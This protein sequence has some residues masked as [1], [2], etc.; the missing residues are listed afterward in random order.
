MREQLAMDFRA[1]QPRSRATDPDT[2]RETARRIK[3]SRTQI[4][5]DTILGI[6]IM[7]GPQSDEA[8]LHELRNVLFGSTLNN[9]G[10]LQE[11]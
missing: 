3:L 11:R 4:A 10:R 2:S 6:L 5:R 8:I 1:T 9:Y 7:H